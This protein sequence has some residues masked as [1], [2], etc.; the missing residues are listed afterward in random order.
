MATFLALAQDVARESG[1]VPGS[2]LP[3]T[4]VGQTGRLASIVGWTDRAWRMIQNHRSH[5]RWMRGEFAGNT[6][7]ATQRYSGADLNATRF[8]VFSYSGDSDEES[9]SIAPAGNPDDEGGLTYLDWPAFHATRLRGANRTK[10]GQPINFTIDP[11]GELVL[12]PIPDAAYTVRGL[13]RKDVQSLTAD[14]DVPEMPARFHDLIVYRALLLLAAN[15]EAVTQF[16][17]WRIEYSKMMSEL[18]RDQL[19]IITLPGPIA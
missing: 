18:E 16:P 3:S 15:D 7:A 10:Q 12:W 14:A 17:L 6:V 5:W 4:V 11:Q 1:T 2:G 13:Y 8:A 19:P 9:F